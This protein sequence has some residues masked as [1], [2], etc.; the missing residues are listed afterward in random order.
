MIEVS[1]EAP[2]GARPLSAEELDAVIN[3][4]SETG[5]QLRAR[6]YVEAISDGGL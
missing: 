4:D 6:A 1:I 5:R 3:G 2:G